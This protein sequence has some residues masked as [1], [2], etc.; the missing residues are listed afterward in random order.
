MH[1]RIDEGSL[2]GAGSEPVGAGSGFGSGLASTGFVGAG[3]GAAFVGFGAGFVAPGS[4][5]GVAATS[6]ASPFGQ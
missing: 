1:H 6:V 4:A 2:F 5:V 3:F